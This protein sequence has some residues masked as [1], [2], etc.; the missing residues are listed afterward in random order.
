MELLEEPIRREY[1]RFLSLLPYQEPASKGLSAADVLRAHFLIANHF[2]IQDGELGG[3]G[4]RSVDLLLSAVD[5][6]YVGYG[7]K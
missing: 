7:K 5:R 6:Q 3:I 1:E 4:P 2:Y